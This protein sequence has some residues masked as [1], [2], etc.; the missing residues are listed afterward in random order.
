[1]DVLFTCFEKLLKL[2]QRVVHLSDVDVWRVV[3]CQVLNSTSR[4]LA[5]ERGRLMDLH[6]C[7]INFKLEDSEFRVVSKLGNK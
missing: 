6:I 4:H 3:A 1:M 7:F 2:V 5:R